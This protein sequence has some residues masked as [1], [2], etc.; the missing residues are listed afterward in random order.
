MSVTQYEIKFSELACHAVWLVPTERERIRRFIDDL[1]YGLCFVMTRENVSGAMFNG[2]VDI[3]RWLELV[4][5][6]EH[7]EREAKRPRGS[8][9]F[10]G[11]SSRGQSHH[12]RGRPYRH[13][14]MARPVHRGASTSHSSY[15]ACPVP[16]IIDGSG[17]LR[18]W[19]AWT[20]EEVLSPY[21]GSSVEFLGHVV[22]SEGIKV[23]LKKIEAVQSWPRPSLAT[24][25]QSFL[26][27]ARYYCR[28]VED[29]SSIAATAL[30]T[31]LVLILPSASGSYT[32]YCD[33]SR[34]GIGCI[35]MLECRVIAYA[36]RQ[37][38]PY[39]KNY[40]A[41]VVTDALSRKT[42]SMGSLAFIPVGDRPLAT[43]VQSLANQFVR[44]DISEPSRVLACVVSLS[45]LYDHIREHQYDDPH[46]LALK[47]TVQHSDVKEVT[48]GDDG[49]LRMEGRIC[50]PNVDRLHELILEEAHSSRYS[51]HPGATEMYQNL[52]QHYWWRRMKKDI[53]RL[54]QC[55]HLRP[56]FRICDCRNCKQEFTIAMPA[57]GY[58]ELDAVMCE[59]WDLVQNKY[60]V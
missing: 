33:A 20:C 18:V 22:S 26:G 46:L 45:F 2:V 21:L 15:S 24:E 30:T 50:V 36:S 44:L 58:G 4:R 14:Q 13:A 35:L 43:D 47:D 54:G 38:K 51:I 19:G 8:G 42:V 59:G 37:L 32:M 40:L 56:V 60:G 31:T 53:V 49:V 28:F 11:V 17:L 34:I 55:L 1:N 57:S 39:E 6:Q 41:N 29:F 16:T 3:S 9:G 25:I 52:R 5:S 7:E 10:G 27:L 23:D 48:I 12:G